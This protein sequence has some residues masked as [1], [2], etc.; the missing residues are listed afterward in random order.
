MTNSIYLDNAASTPADPAVVERIVAVMRTTWGNPSAGNPQGARARHVIAEARRQVLAALGDGEPSGAG[1]HADRAPSRGEVI[2]TSGCTESDALAVLGAAATGPGEVVLTTLEHPAVEQ[3][4]RRLEAAGRVVRRI[5]PGP[6][7][8]MDPD[9]LAEAAVRARLVCL[10][11]VQNEVG[12]VQPI[13]TLAAAIKARAPRCHLHLDAAQAFGKIELCAG[14]LPVDSIAL[15]AHK[16]HG[17]PGVGALWLHRDAHL[18]PLWGGGGQQ[19]GLRSG[20]QNAPGAAGLGLA[21]ELAMTRRSAAQE[22]WRALSAR[23]LDV[24]RHRETSP[25]WLL[26]EPVRAPHILALG[27]RQVSA[28]ALR[29]TLASRGVA[30][31]TGS[32]CA[33]DGGHGSAALAAA[34]LTPDVAMVRLSFGWQNELSEVELAARHLADIVTELRG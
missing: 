13:A 14:R 19:G 10:V 3:N 31:S 12:L 33:T 34:G 7:G 4:A 27:F 15:T 16:F 2:W 20:T 28:E 25:A 26:P 30:V 9:T 5:P 21:A 11:A 6:D 8:V 17:P 32:A 29:N 1:G 23:V 22:R 24:L 18:A